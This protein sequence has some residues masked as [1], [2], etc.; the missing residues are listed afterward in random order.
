MEIR[1]KDP[2]SGGEKGSKPTRFDLIPPAALEALAEHYGRGSQKY[3]DRNW[4][5]GYRY[6]LSFAAMMR[7]AWAWWRGEDNDPETGSSH[8]IAVAWHALALFTF[9]SRGVGRDDRAKEPARGAGGAAG[10]G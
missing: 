5:R 2:V 8:M 10:G 1:E 7:H 6:G 4:E 9:R 3:E